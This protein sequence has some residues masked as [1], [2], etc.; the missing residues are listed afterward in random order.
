M[1]LRLKKIIERKKFD[2]EFVKKAKKEMEEFMKWFDRED[3][4]KNLMIAYELLNSLFGLSE[5]DTILLNRYYN[6]I[7]FR[8]IFDKLFT[9]Y[10]DISKR[11]IN[12]NLNLLIKYPSESILYK[13][14]PE[15]ALNLL[16]HYKMVYGSPL[17]KEFF[18]SDMINF[19]TANKINTW[20]HLEI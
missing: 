17:H 3:R 18:T 15:F 16:D 11:I 8:V 7:K 2:L 1:S 5:P 10:R 20:L 6:D 9:F 19:F 4:F 14:N 13:S 12:H